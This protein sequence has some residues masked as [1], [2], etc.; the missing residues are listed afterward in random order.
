M[1]TFIYAMMAILF[2]ASIPSASELENKLVGKWKEEGKTKVL[3]FFK[4]NTVTTVN[5]GKSSVGE[6]QFLDEDRIKMSLGGI[7]SLAGSQLFTI[8]ISGN[9]LYLTDLNGNGSKYLRIELTKKDKKSIKNAFQANMSFINENKKDKKTLDMFIYYKDGKGSTDTDLKHWVAI[10]EKVKLD[11][12]QI[13]N[14]VSVDHDKAKVTL[15][16]K[17]KGESKIEI[18]TVFKVNGNWY[19]G[20]EG[21]H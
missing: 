17:I 14:I 15:K 8:I 20:V 7:S 11:S 9:T 12:P 5:R 1:K 16:Y 13:I 3:E 19:L 21:H 2:I 10:Y 6:Y 18:E 4:G